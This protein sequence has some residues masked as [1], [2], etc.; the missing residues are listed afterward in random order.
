M[1]GGLWPELW[2][3]DLNFEPQVGVGCRGGPRRTARAV[4]QR[5]SF[6]GLVDAP[7]GGT[8]GQRTRYEFDI[9]NRG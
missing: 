2:P 4:G 1:G 7:P 9:Q 8:P 5:R 3:E 6:Q